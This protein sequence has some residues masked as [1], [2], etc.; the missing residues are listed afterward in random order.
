VEG[1]APMS[2]EEFLERLE[3]EVTQWQRERLVTETQASAILAWYER[4]QGE[5]GRGRLAV[6]LAFLGAILVGIGVIVLFAANWQAIP[7]WTK[8]VLIFAA[9]IASNAIGF[10][11]RY[12]HHGFEGTGNALLFLG[13]LLFGAAIFL[14]AQGYHVNAHEPALL[15]LWAVGVLPMAYLLGSRAMVT[16]MALNLTLALGWETSFWLGW[17]QLFRPFP[18]FAVYLLFGVLLY[19]LGRLHGAF[20][21]TKPYELPVCRVGPVPHPGQP[22]PAHLWRPA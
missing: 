20:E 4:G 18:Y 9:V 2:N 11:L 1:E 7:G 12:Q 6:A 19:A 3:G 5:Q 22:L 13:T 16:L 8:L 15:L 10:W 21:R 14:I 17:E